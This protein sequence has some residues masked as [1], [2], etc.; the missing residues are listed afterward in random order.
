MAFLKPETLGIV[1]FISPKD[2]AIDLELDDAT[3]EPKS[4]LE[5]YRETWDFDSHCM[6][7]E[8]HEPT[9]FKINFALSHK[10]QVIIDNASLG[11]DGKKEEFGFK[12][13]KHKS[14]T[15][16]C[17]LCGI[18]NPESVPPAQRLTFKRDRHGFA[19]DALLEE[20]GRFGI[21]DDIYSFYLT[22]KEN[23]GPLK[24]K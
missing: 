3:G 17:V 4:D 7:K 19:D 16:K 8:G 22:H 10:K 23:T 1:D 13:G 18:E 6:L 12:L 9:R 21:L 15:V 20:L 11:G 2:D 5:K 14:S 24:K